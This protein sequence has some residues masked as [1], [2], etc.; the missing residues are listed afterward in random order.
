MA[1]AQLLDRHF[2]LQLAHAG[3]NGLAGFS[4]V[5]QPEARVL[6]KQGLQCLGQALLVRARLGL[7]GHVNH[8]LG[9]A[10][11][12]QHHRVGRIAQGVPCQCVLQAD[13]SGDVARHQ[14]VAFDVLVG[15]YFVQA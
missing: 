10:D 11:L 9:H 14:F 12:L 15:M 1:C 2:E 4:V 6:A 5:L 8:R 13:H 7:D 3:Q